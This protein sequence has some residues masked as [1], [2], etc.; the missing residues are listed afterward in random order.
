M[1]GNKILKSDE[2]QSNY[3]KNHV[4]VPNVHWY[5]KIIHQFHIQYL[6]NQS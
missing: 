2:N 1:S 5:E 6:W 4:N 3:G